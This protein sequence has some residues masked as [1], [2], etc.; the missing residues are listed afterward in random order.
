MNYGIETIETLAQNHYKKFVDLEV[1]DN[2]IEMSKIIERTQ[3]HSLKHQFLT[4]WPLTKRC[5]LINIK[6]PRQYFNCLQS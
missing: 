2:T 1:D 4:I 5:F 3:N 6:D